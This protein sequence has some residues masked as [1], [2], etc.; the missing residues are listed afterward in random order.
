MGET[1]ESSD[2]SADTEA[3]EAI[4]ADEAVETADAR[5]MVSQL[6]VRSCTR[7][8]LVRVVA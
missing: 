6:L 7:I 3:I 8:P 2:V 5:S 4:E 1:N